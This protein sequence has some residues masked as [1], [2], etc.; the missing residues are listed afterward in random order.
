MQNVI[1]S[2]LQ[3][4]EVGKGQFIIRSLP[5]VVTLIAIGGLFDFG[6]YHGP[7]DAQSMDN[8]QLA[9]QIARGQGYTTEFLR[10][11]ALTQLQNYVSSQTLPGGTHG[12]LFPVKDFPTGK[13]RIVP[14]TYN[15]PGYPTLLAAVFNLTR[16]N[17]DQSMDDMMK[18]R[19]YAPDIIIPILNQIFLLLT[20]I[21]V[22]VLSLRLFDQR[23]A[24]LSIVVFFGCNLIWQ[25]SLTGLS[26][27]LLMFLVT[28]MFFCIPEIL[29]ISEEC[30]ES[31]E[32]SFSRAWLWAI[33]MALLL[34]LICLTRLHLL[35]LLVP[36]MVFLNLMPK[37]Q[38]LLTVLVGLI[39]VAGVA[40]WY[41]HFY[42]VSGSIL[43][44]NAAQL[45]YGQ[46]EYQNDQI[47]CA[48]SIP[49]YESL[50]RFLGTKECSGLDWTLEHAWTLLGASVAILFY[51]AAILH[52]FKR[53]KTQRFHLLVLASA[54]C[55]VVVNSLGVDNPDDLGPWNIL[56]LFFPCMVVIGCAFFFILLDRIGTQVPILR[57]LIVIVFLVLA[58]VPLGQNL[59]STLRSHTF[60][61]Y[62]PYA[63]PLIKALSQM[64]QPDEWVTSDMPW[65]T[66]WYGDRGSL[67]IPDTVSDFE[68]FHDNYCPS[69]MLI[70]TP[71]TWSKQLNELTDGEKKDWIAF[72][73]N[74]RVPEGFPLAI[75]SAVP[76]PGPA[77]SLWS[78]RARWQK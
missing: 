12:E 59:S 14:D 19:L 57:N 46:G 55:A 75:R 13:P 25:Y 52:Q 76:K 72:Y 33:F 44:S 27:S 21:L 28:A 56:I 77:Y 7:N 37:T 29:S 73:T 15:A 24:W 8:A 68:D 51:G 47:F 48:S 10:P 58:A 3:S 32:A 26:T 60:Y 63:P 40:P 31:T 1:Q 74:S 4:L 36:V 45:M 30:F 78:D 2:M 35:V 49:G 64:A 66:A 39:V 22:F 62:P 69:G 9:R 71:V 67:W 5:L 38:S 42:A 23:V 65:A 54:F 53:R 6:A 34:T 70:L 61:N 17:F 50:F 41:W 18:H 20:G 11:Y 16:T 43:G